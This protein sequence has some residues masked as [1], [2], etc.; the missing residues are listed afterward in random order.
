MIPTYNPGEYLRD[1][2]ASVL[3]QDPGPD[4][5]QIMVVDDCSPQGD[6]AAIVEEVGRGRVEYYRQPQNIGI[7]KNFQACIELAR[8]QLV[9]LLHGDDCVREGFYPKIQQLFSK[10]P[11]IG[12]A[13]CR[14]IIMDE[15]GHWQHI[16]VLEQPESGVLPSQWLKELAGFIRI[17]TPSIVVR[18]EVYEKLG[19]F[20][21]RLPVVGDWEM[22]V[23]VA[24]YYPIG[25][26]A[27]PLALYR[28]HSNSSTNRTVSNG[29]YFRQLHEAVNIFQEYLPDAI[30]D[31]AYKLAM[32][33]CAFHTLEIADS[34][35]DTGD[36]RT[37]LML[38]KEALQCSRSFK[39]VRSAGRILLLDGSAWLWHQVRTS[40][41]GRGGKNT[42]TRNAVLR[43]NA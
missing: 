14:H 28:K 16:S 5:M 41:T 22:W 43:S 18:R 10:H 13:F 33:N 38:L 29:S 11:E 19:A 26:E 9:H 37:T 42:E 24:A 34:I 39:V 12:A 36:M 1:T 31:Q 23:R 35:L 40:L 17:Q 6:V 15:N 32:Q 2:L 25:Y 27:E 21:D 3:A 20:D 8:G 7:T 4:V 30:A